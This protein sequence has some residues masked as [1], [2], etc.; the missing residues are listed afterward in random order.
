M[1]YRFVL[2][3]CQ[4]ILADQPFLRISQE[5]LQTV[6]RVRKYPEL[7]AKGPRTPR[8]LYCSFDN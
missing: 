1:D 3:G 6:R 2:N 8:N 4:A 7:T 5:I